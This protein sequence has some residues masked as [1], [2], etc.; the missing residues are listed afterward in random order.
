MPQS[1]HTLTPHQNKILSLAKS[2]PVRYF[3]PPGS[4]WSGIFIT[5]GT[6]F[7][8]SPLL[9]ALIHSQLSSDWHNLKERKNS[10]ISSFLPAIIDFRKEQLHGHFEEPPDSMRWLCPGK[11]DSIGQRAHPTQTGH[12]FKFLFCV[13]GFLSFYFSLLFFFLI[14]KW[15]RITKY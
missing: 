15:K 8:Y 10:S 7:Q 6:I 4:F 14:F 9:L 12:V 5:A 11:N 13:C 3:C 2:F 1:V